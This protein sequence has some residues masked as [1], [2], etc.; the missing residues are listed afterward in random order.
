MRTRK[1]S[2]WR[3]SGSVGSTDEKW[4]REDYQELT[5]GKALE[6]KGFAAKGPQHTGGRV[7][8]ISARELARQELSPVRYVVH[9]LVPEGQPF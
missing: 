6:G 4:E 8:I 3:L 2:V 5:I 9:R 7:Q 1:L